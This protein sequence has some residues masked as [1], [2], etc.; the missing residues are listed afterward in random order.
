MSTSGG[1]APLSGSSQN[2]ELMP[3]VAVGSSAVTWK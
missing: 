1:Q 2:A 3:E